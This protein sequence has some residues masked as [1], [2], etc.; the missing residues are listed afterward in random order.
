MGYK[1]GF[2]HNMFFKLFALSL[3]SGFEHIV[4]GL[5]RREEWLENNRHLLSA[6]MLLTSF[7]YLEGMLSSTWIEDFGEEFQPELYCLRI[8]RNAITH[9]DGDISLNRR[10]RGL[11]G[12]QQLQEVINFKESLEQNTYAPLNNWQPLARTNYISFEDTTV[13]LGNCAIGRIGM[14]GHIIMRNSGLIK[15]DEHNTE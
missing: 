11:T 5:P 7:S 12:E 9:N 1:E 13:K 14:L 15:Y 10:A 4:E 6:A 3:P 2:D 8:I